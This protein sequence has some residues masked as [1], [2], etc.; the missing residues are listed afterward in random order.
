MVATLELEEKKA[1][2]KKLE[3]ELGIWDAK[4]DI[5]EANFDKVKE[6]HKELYRRDLNEIIDLRDEAKREILRLRETSS[7][8]WKLL[9]EGADKLWLELEYEIEKALATFK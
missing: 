7:E 5:L 6:E 3:D 1:Y 4:I 9:K 8:E 2:L